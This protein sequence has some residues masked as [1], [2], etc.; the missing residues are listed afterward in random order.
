MS[1]KTIFKCLPNWGIYLSNLIHMYSW[2]ICILLY[3]KN[4]YDK[5]RI[6]IYMKYPRLP[7][8]ANGN[9]IVH[10]GKSLENLLMFKIG[11]CCE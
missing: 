5:K 4:N 2:N 1:N 3:I 6:T 10:L 7:S 11:I 8:T 9:T